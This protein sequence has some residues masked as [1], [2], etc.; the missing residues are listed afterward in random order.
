LE[1]GEHVEVRFG[2]AADAERALAEGRFSYAAKLLGLAGAMLP[3]TCELTTAAIRAELEL[4]VYRRNKE[5]P[6]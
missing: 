5:Y 3:A 6:P 2:S 4:A 1:T